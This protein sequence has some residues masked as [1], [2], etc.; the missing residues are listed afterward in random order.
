MSTVTKVG[1]PSLSTL[2]PGREHQQAGDKFAGEAIAAGDFVYMRADGTIWRSIANVAIVAG[3]MASCDTLGVVFIPAQAGDPVTIHEHVNMQYGAGLT[4][5]QKF[6]LS[7]TVPGG[8]D[9]VPSA[10]AVIPCGFAVDGTRI[11]V[12]RILN[13]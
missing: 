11:Q 7:A 12:L 8:I 13:P 1:R 3:A 6:Y 5:G 9:T 4:Y 10:N 2:T